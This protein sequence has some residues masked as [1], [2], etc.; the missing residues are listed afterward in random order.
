MRHSGVA[1][2]ISINYYLQPMKSASLNE[3][4]KELVVLPARDL[5]ELCIALA[6]YKK[7]N[8]DFLNYLLFD[9]QDNSTYVSEIKK[10]IDEHF[11]ELK[12]Q[13]NLY[14][15][16]KSLRKLL[17]QITRYSRYINNKGISADLLIYFCLKVKASGISI[18]KSQLLVNMY[19]QQLKKINTLIGS[20][21]EDLQND[22][23]RDLEKI[24]L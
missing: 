22:Y 14:Y 2:F 1:F 16:K 19:E 15:I 8:K 21:H 9:A 20:L 10:E 18:R 6:K 17:R 12:A 7:D 13:Q 23:L 3:L 11:E 5:A 24:N 4:K